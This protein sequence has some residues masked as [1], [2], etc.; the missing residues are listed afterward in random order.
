MRDDLT[1]TYKIINNVD[2]M[3]VSNFLKFSSTAC[4]RNSIDKLCVNYSRAN[5]RKFSLSNRVPP[6]WNKLHELVKK[7]PNVN[8]FKN[9]TDSKTVL[10]IYFMNLMKNT[11]IGIT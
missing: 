5:I 7:A 6:V 8:T 11:C 1:Q 10:W 3:K 9:A 4:T 2:D